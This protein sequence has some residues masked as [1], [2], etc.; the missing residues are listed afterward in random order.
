MEQRDLSRLDGRWIVVTGGSKGIGLGIA[1]ELLRRGAHVGI[2]ARNPDDLATARKELEAAA[3]A[4]AE[5]AAF[6]A[7]T[8]DEADVARLEGEL[9]DRVPALSGFVA[10][11]GTGGLTSFLDLDVAEWDRIMR[12]NLRGTFLVSQLAARLMIGSR[13]ADPDGDR[14]LLVVSSV[15]AHQ[16]RPGT[17]PYSCTKAALN[18]FV[19]A[20]AVELAP[21]RIRV[22]AV[23]P[24]MTVTPLM[25]ERTPN[26]E[27]I[28]AQR[29]PFGRAGQ[30]SDVAQASA[31]LL[32]AA[33]G[34][35]TGAN[36][37]VDGGEALI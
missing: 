22:N 33:A 34:F 13:E 17:L 37:A 26:V 4:G 29:I 35:V 32:S 7:D 20:V 19:R 21:H 1:H 5:V 3:P 11:A 30:P 8:G 9:R 23:A 31:Y 27:D 24:G 14:S 10:N 25:L 18:Q 16:F 36:L 15:R 2:V 6:R 12:V 28:A